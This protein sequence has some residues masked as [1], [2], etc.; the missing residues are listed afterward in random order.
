L[1][2][3]GQNAAGHSV[4]VLDAQ[5]AV[6]SVENPDSPG[7]LPPRLA[8]L[9]ESLPLA[10]TCGFGVACRRILANRTLAQ[11]IVNGVDFTMRPRCSSE[12]KRVAK[13]AKQ[14]TTQP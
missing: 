11:Q 10:F 9:I 6:M 5:F 1:G 8:L 12:T 2:E 14:A 4:G 13:V 3:P 7:P